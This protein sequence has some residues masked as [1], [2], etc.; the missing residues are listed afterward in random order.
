MFEKILRIL[1]DELDLL[2]T[3]PLSI[4]FLLFLIILYPLLKIKVGFLHSD[5]IGHFT[6]NTELYLLEKKFRNFKSLDLFYLGRKNVCNKTLEKLWRKKLIILP[7]LILRP[8]CLQIR[9]FDNLSFLRCGNTVNGQRDI[10]NLLDEYP[11]SINFEEEDHKFG[12]K[13]MEKLGIPKNTKYV[14]LIVRDSAYLEKIYNQKVSIHDYR[15]SNINHFIEAANA[16]TDLG[17][18]VIRMGAKVN[19]P[20]QAKNKMVID[21]AFEGQRSDFMDIYLASKCEFCITTGTGFDGVTMLFRKP[22]VYVN[23]APLFYLRLECSNLLSIPCYY[24]SKI[25]KRK[26]SL[27][28]IINSNSAV[29]LNNSEYKNDSIELIQ[30]NS[31]EIKMTV[32]EAEKRIK[33]TWSD[34]YADNLHDKFK[35]L[36]PQKKIFNSLIS[37]GKIKG[38]ISSY[39]LKK[40]EWWLN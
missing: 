22:N 5:R 29:Y 32:L 26:L 19:E 33:G 6:L 8:L 31:E 16:L 12:E 39:F 18:Y 24:Y 4:P 13:E 25:L 34:K 40:N 27:L 10:L 2:I 35:K 23:V 38:R 28:E 30:N 11:A 15:N 20:I 14:C 9:F 37:H 17:Y 36:F 1:K 7:R 3:I 21:Y